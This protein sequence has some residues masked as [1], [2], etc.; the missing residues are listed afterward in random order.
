MIGQ[1]VYVGRSAYVQVNE[2]G[3]LEALPPIPWY[4][5]LRLYLKAYFGHYSLQEVRNAWK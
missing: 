1:I 2:Q 4:R 3:T 5:Q